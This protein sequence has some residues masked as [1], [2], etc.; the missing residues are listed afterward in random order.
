[1]KFKKSLLILTLV[2][3]SYLS[4]CL[5]NDE[6]TMRREQEQIKEELFREE[7]L[8]P[9]QNL[10]LLQLYPPN[11]GDQIAIIKT[12]L[13]DIK[14]RFFLKCAPQTCE[15]FLNLAKRG[16]FDNCLFHRVIPGFIIQTGDPTGTGTGGESIY[17]GYFEDEIAFPFR[18]IHLRAAVSM[19]NIGPNT[20]TSQFFVV[21]ANSDDLSF[22]PSGPMNKH[23]EVMQ[24][25]YERFGGC[26][27]LDGKHT[28]FADVF[29][30]MDVVDAISICETDENDKPKDEI[31]IIGIELGEYHKEDEEPSTWEL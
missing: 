27:H 3:V 25:A 5:Y 6:E 31:K 12:S 30:G 29:S 8:N 21:L 16:Y 4:G 23:E 7:E 26:P 28:V 13:G 15:N 2:G 11:E 1:M 10:E 24:S 14:I 22:P 18:L 19:A 9:N 20:N 17:G